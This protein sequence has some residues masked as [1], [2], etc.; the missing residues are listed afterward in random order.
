MAVEK[1]KHPISEAAGARKHPI[2]EMNMALNQM[3]NRKPLKG[4]FRMSRAEKQG[5]MRVIETAQKFKPYT[6]KG[7]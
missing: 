5:M 3:E 6:K 2:M 1:K 4:D 7:P